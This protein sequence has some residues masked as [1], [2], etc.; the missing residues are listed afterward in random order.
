MAKIKHNNFMD[1]VDEVFSEAKKEGVLHLYA[2]GRT[3]NGRTIEIKG[4][5]RF[6]FGTTGYLGLEQ[7]E[8][9]KN[10]AI[11]AIKNYGTQFP[12]SKSYISHPLY[13][14]LEEKVEQM[15]GIP[16][17]IAKNSTLGHLGV[18]PSLIRDE[19]GVILDHQVHWS[20]QNACQL[21]KL[22]GIPV[23]MIRHN[24]LTML[25]DKI[26][27]MRNKCNKIW[28]M[29]DGVYSMYGDFAPIP[30][31]LKLSEKYPCLHFYFDDVHGMSWKGKNGTG[32]V[33]DTL[34]ELPENV[35]IM[36][37]LSKT[38]GASGAI[39]LC[40]DNKLREK[41]RIF[42]GPLTFSAQLE[43]ASVG[44]AI[45]SAKIHLSPEIE[46][47]QKDLKNKIDWMNAKIEEFKLPLICKN[48]AP[49]FFLGTAAPVTGFNLVNKMLN[50][51]F[52]LNLGIYPAVPI[53]N[54]GLRITI[55]RH[56]TID[57]IVALT[58]ALAYNYPKA[59]EETNMT[60]FKIGRSFGKP[61][62]QKGE[63][64]P[65][66]V[67]E[68]LKLELYHSIHQIDQN[69][70]N[71]Y[72]SGKN[73][74][75]ALGMVFLE[76]AFKEAS[77]PEHKTEFI[78]AI[79][80][81]HENKVV[82]MTFFTY[83]LWKEDML[84]TDSI[85]LRFEEKRK[86]NPYYMTTKVLGMGSLFTEGEHCYVNTKHPMATQAF[87]I[88]LDTA[89]KMY[90][91]KEANM[92]ALRDFEVDN[93]LNK[94]ILDH[95][96][97]K[98]EMPESCISEIGHWN[99]HDEFIN[100]LSTRS[101]KHFKKEV[102]PFE[103]EFIVEV[104]NELV[105]TELKKAYELYKN[106][107]NKNLAVNT[108]TMPYRVFI[109]MNKHINWEFILLRL[110]NNPEKHIAGVMFCYKNIGK[111]YVPEWIGMDYELGANFGVYRQLLYQ[112]IKRAKEL[113]CDR[114]DFGITAS[115]EKK[116]LGAEVIPKVAYIQARDNYSLELMGMI[117]NENKK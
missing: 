33:M 55:S 19:D 90:H 87:Q 44:A 117:Q 36:A 54:T 14:T 97:F 112:T 51:G 11:E 89:E 39:F 100:Q 8:R 73:M 27:E 115:F 26:I 15:Y 28:Y 79:V 20:V 104:K 18:I 81:D 65:T 24:N 6:H 12:L 86:E 22:R 93:V 10:E 45:A 94:S 29:A 102:E 62:F 113:N 50:E 69:L 114:I 57:D 53:K 108:F 98:I 106:V 7:D 47:L 91:D 35:V 96:F 109:E 25:E 38:F 83:G 59:L 78:Y 63:T 34:G 41:I 64:S 74:F 52:Y 92:L 2:E 110:K 40:S 80:K 85:S 1:T 37:T 16:A 49:V 95:G 56:N 107:K 23:E 70:W 116:K 68:N 3:F 105:E 21:L 13:R 84:A 77:E 5:E 42:G 66:Q 71:E 46:V 111:N 48:E 60:M 101:R 58:E 4:R 30:E 67:N 9:L 82:V 75:D 88:L 76:N 61:E 103:K 43:P 72:M 99:N 17:I 32:Y 31:L